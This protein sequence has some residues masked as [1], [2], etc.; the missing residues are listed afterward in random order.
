MR[1]PENADFEIIV[2]GANDI[3]NSKNIIVQICIATPNNYRFAL[4]RGVKIDIYGS[5]LKVTPS[6]AQNIQQHVS[7]EFIEHFRKPLLKATEIFKEHTDILENN[8]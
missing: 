2:T 3:A 5:V 6:A 4:E 8:N 1:K 7:K